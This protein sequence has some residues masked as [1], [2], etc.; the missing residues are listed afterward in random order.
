[1][2]ERALSPFGLEVELPE[3]TSWDEV[4]IDRLH[5]WIA[6]HR[7]V[8][9]RGLEAMTKHELPA[10]ARRLGP[11]QPWSFGSVHELEPDDDAKNYLY[12]RRGVPLHWDG[13]FAPK[14]P[15]YLFFQCLAAPGPG[16]GGE[17]LFVDT[18]KIWD[19]CDTPTR[20]RLRALRF[21]YRTERV[22]HYGGA[23]TARVVAQHPHHGCTVLRFAEPVDDLNP[24]SVDAV[25]LGPLESA[26]MVTDLRARLYQPEVVLAHAWR[27]GDVV[28]ADNHALL[29]GRNGF[30]A[31]A[32]RHIR[33]INVFGPART[34]K[35]TIADSLKIRRPEFMVAEIP[36]LL[37][38]ALLAVG[39][40]SELASAT[41]AAT[42]VMFFLLFHFGDMI[43]CLC[44]R[45]L[46]AVYKT[47]L[48][49][50]VYGLGVGNVRWQI[51]L[52]VIGALG[53]SAWIALT[54]GRLEVIAL[55]AFGLALGSQYSARPL[56]LKGRGLLQIVTLWAVIFVGPMV[57]VARSL[58]DSLSIAELLLFGCYGAMQQ[59]IVLVNTAEDLPE[60]RASG[61]RTSAIALGLTGSVALSLAMI[62]LG[63]AG[64]IVL[65][66]ASGRWSSLVPLVL[67]WGWVVYDVASLARRVWGL[68][69]TRALVRLRKAA[70]RVPI[71]ITV[72]A[73][74]TLIAVLARTWS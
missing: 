74:G 70:K 68:D 54:T 71:W 69:E 35:D 15:R 53:L 48:S 61:I 50:A 28:V 1:V 55:A 37:V 64:V 6:E 36:I 32:P 7:V 10:A 23:F 52:T 60:D 24:V 29:H 62:V 20:D 26:A 45:D 49:E 59:G 5:A 42:A 31:D 33:R 63:G 19:A 51:A 8:V 12:T 25:G 67:A 18:T 21:E 30:C 39:S 38:A 34:W 2:I 66:A 65:L 46:D 40:A 43:N 47:H 72:T 58:D 17:T 4:P 27:E 57:L 22:V 56:W 73:W 16:E 3:G 41:F 13:A 11:L 9:L 44:D 14:V